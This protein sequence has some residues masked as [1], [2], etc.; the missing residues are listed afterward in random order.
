MPST[1]LGTTVVNERVFNTVITRAKSLF[2]AVGNPHYLMDAEECMVNEE[3]QDTNCW[4]EYLKTCASWNSIIYPS[5]SSKE[6]QGELLARVYRNNMPFPH[7]VSK[8]ED[9]ILQKSKEE[10][11]KKLLQW[12][13]GRKV[14]LH[15]GTWSLIQA[16]KRIKVDDTEDLRMVAGSNADTGLLHCT[17]VDQAEVMPIDRNGKNYKVLGV[18]CRRGALHGA[19]VRVKPTVSGRAGAPD[20]P[21]L[22]RVVEVIRQGPR[23]T[24]LC[25][26][27]PNNSNYMIPLDGKNPKFVN[28]PRIARLL[29]SNE[30]MSAANAVMKQGS[31]ACFDRQSLTEEDTPRL[32]D[33]IPVEDAKK[34]KFL[35]LFISWKHK[36]TFPLGAVI[37]AYPP[38]HPIAMSEECE[39]EVPVA[40]ETHYHRDS[41]EYDFDYGWESKS[42]WNSDEY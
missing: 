30:N 37:E 29:E 6:Q 40:T 9:S 27:D 42:S 2:V 12:L 34:M 11:R 17:K 31:V 39:V 25:K 4:K 15:Q 10:M 28:L 21:L 38:N 5:S 8:K 16:D 7:D 1:D 18:D 36:Y 13:K 24:F 32:R 41:T 20:V 3:H 14:E 33:V 19:L 22:G 26:M 35:V 23:E